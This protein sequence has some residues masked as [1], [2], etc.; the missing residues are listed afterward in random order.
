MLIVTCKLNATCRDTHVR[1][2]GMLHTA[3]LPNHWWLILEVPLKL[4]QH[5]SILHGKKLLSQG[6]SYFVPRNGLFLLGMARKRK[7]LNFLGLEINAKLIRRCLDSVHLSGINNGYFIA[8]NATSTFRSIVSSYPG[9]L[10]LVSIQCPNPD[11]NR[12][13]HRWRMLQRSLVEA[14]ADLLGYE[15][16]VLFYC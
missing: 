11:F 10:I 12:P 14:V 6:M 1:L 15:G 7:D 3:I 16:K 4:L 13:E 8:T 2:T 5:V 9:K